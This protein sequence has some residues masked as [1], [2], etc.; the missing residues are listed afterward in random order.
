MRGTKDKEWYKERERRANLGEIKIYCQGKGGIAEK[1]NN[2]FRQT[3][4]IY[5]DA[6]SIYN[7]GRALDE[8][9]SVSELMLR[10]APCLCAING[11]NG[12][13]RSRKNDKGEWR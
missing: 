2:F 3:F 7:I 13:H 9:I 10:C 5:K 12:V 6:T 1:F 8:Q 11:G 4:S